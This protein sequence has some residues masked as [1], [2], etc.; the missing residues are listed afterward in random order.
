MFEKFV[1]SENSLKNTT[2]KGKAGFQVLTRLNY[3]RGIPLS[4][5]EGIALALDGQ[6]IP[7]DKVRF[8]VDED[9]FTLDELPTVTSVR[10]EYATRA[11]I[12]VEWPQPLAGTHDVTLAQS[13]RTAYIPF[14]LQARNTRTMTAS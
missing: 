6:E 7:R 1:L 10:W 3:Y 9:W 8:A 12:F 2:V 11:R 4:Q 14:P 5:I 13:I